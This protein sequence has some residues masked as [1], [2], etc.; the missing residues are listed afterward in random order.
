MLK[1]YNIKEISNLE[2]V[3]FSMTME[4]IK[5]HRDKDKQLHTTKYVKKDLH[6]IELKYY[7]GEIVIPST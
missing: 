3:D 1:E 5:R 4:I 6:G 7:K 2:N